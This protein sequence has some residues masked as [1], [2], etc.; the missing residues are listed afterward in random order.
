MGSSLKGATHCSMMRWPSI[1]KDKASIS[2]GLRRAEICHPHGAVLACPNR[3]QPHVDGCIAQRPLGLLLD[4]P[5]RSPMVVQDQTPSIASPTEDKNP[6][7]RCIKSHSGAGR[8][9]IR[10]SYGLLDH[11]DGLDYWGD[12]LFHFPR[13]LLHWRGFGLGLGNHWLRRFSSRSL[14]H[15]ACLTRSLS[16]TTRALFFLG[17]TEAAIDG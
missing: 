9:L 6:L 12:G 2:T 14:G 1:Q 15:L 8:S 5:T 17:R 11:L 16:A 4:V 3:I 7:R 10:D 13:S